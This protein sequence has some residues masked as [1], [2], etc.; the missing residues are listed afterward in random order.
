MN[1]V[2]FFYKN[3]ASGKSFKWNI[4]FFFAKNKRE[5]FKFF[6]SFGTI[7][8]RVWSSECNSDVFRVE[9]DSEWFRLSPTVDA[10][11]LPPSPVRYLQHSFSWQLLSR[12][13]RRRL[14]LHSTHFS[15]T[16]IAYND[17]IF[18]D[19]KKLRITYMSSAG[20]PNTWNFDTSWRNVFHR[21]VCRGVNS[22]APW[23]GH[24]SVL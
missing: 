19:C 17:L 10:A 12:H 16:I 6:L 20:G 9:L 4:S 18:K 15:K 8:D 13:R 22:V 5:E 3:L 21:S 24:G 11:S 14:H 23:S 7:R 1:F 2:F